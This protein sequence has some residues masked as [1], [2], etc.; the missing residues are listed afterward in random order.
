LNFKVKKHDQRIQDWL[1]I[2]S[3]YQKLTRLMFLHLGVVQKNEH[4]FV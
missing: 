2:L 4:C 3:I 1:T